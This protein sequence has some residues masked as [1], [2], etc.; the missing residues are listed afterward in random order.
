ARDIPNEEPRPRVLRPVARKPSTR[1]RP[2]HCRK[3]RLVDRRRRPATRRLPGRPARR[4]G[5]G[6]AIEAPSVLPLGE[7][8]R[9]SLPASARNYVGR[10]TFARSSTA[11]SSAADETFILSSIRAR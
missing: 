11:I 5:G 9:W 3:R 2:A 6:A 8:R 1:S 4:G 10:T 7:W